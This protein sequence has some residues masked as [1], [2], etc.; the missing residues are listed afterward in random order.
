M[1]VKQVFL[2][3]ESA[4]NLDLD[5]DAESYVPTSMCIDM[6]AGAGSVV[7]DPIRSHV[8]TSESATHQHRIYHPSSLVRI[9]INKGEYDLASIVSV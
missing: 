5:S 4:K 8:A 3:L 1:A 6:F 7:S 2:Y 9:G